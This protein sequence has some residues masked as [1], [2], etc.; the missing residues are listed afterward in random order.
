MNGPQNI[1]HEVQEHGKS[2]GEPKR[3]HCVLSVERGIEGGLQEY[4][5]P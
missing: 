3:H 5:I 4:Q 2:I 1:V